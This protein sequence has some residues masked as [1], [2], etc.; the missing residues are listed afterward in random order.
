MR[1]QL[2][3]MRQ[4]FVW[5]FA[6]M[7]S[8]TNFTWCCGLNVSRN[9]LPHVPHLHDHAHDPMDVSIPVISIALYIAEESSKGDYN[10]IGLI[11]ATPVHRSWPCRE[12]KT[13][14]LLPIQLQSIEST[15]EVDGYAAQ[16]RLH[17]LNAH[18][19]RYVALI[20]KANGAWWWDCGCREEIG[21]V[22]N[23]RSYLHTLISGN[24][25]SY[26]EYDINNVTTWRIS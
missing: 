21:C 12:C 16:N 3:R 11:P 15:L 6:I 7:A 4:T 19:G 20:V 10:C 23:G 13:M 9:D 8:L 24:K 18:D 1:R 25:P 22:S 26:R 2:S 17:W 14:C 5:I